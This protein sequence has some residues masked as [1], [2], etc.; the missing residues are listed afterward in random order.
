MTSWKLSRDELIDLRDWLEER[1][2][3]MEID[4]G[5]TRDEAIYEARRL[6]ARRFFSNK[7]SEE[8][9]NDGD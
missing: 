9:W 8:E 4:G 1:R 2:A 6:A 7:N 5:L 3:I